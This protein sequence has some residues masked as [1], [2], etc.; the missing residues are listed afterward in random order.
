MAENEFL[1]YATSVVAEGG[2]VLPFESNPEFSV[3]D[4]SGKTVPWNEYLKKSGAF[5]HAHLCFDFTI[6]W[7]GAITYIA[8]AK[9][10]GHIDTKFDFADFARRLKATPPKK[11][12]Y[13]YTRSGVVVFPVR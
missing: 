12:G 3:V 10:R 4:S 13:P 2:C 11:F 6:A 9:Y 8:L 5:S 7:T 1:D